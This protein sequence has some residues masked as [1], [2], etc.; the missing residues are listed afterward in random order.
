MRADPRGRL[1]T[2][3]SAVDAPAEDGGTFGFQLPTAGAG[4]GPRLGQPHVIP[5]ITFDAAYRTNL[6]LAET[7]GLDGAAVR[8]TLYDADGNEAGRDAVDVPRYGQRQF[9]ALRPL[10]GPGG[11]DG[12]ADRARRGVRRRRRRRPSSPSSTTSTTTPSTYV[13]RPARRSRRRGAALVAPLRPPDGR[14]WATA[15]ATVRLGVPAV[16][17]GYCDLPAAPTCP[18]PS[19]P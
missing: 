14:H 2:V 7:T 11:L 12:R 4:R 5:A 8:V 19:S 6:I 9:A 15:A 13:S 18:T 1:L 17:N 3:T 10:G 16:V